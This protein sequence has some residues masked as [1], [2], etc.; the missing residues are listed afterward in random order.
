[1]DHTE[2]NFTGQGGLYTVGIEEELM[3]LDAESLDLANG[4]DRLVAE[5]DGDHIKPELHE[6]V[7]EIATAPCADV[8]EAGAQLRGLRDR[9]RERAAPQG[10][11]IAAAGTHPFAR[12]EDQRISPRPRYRDLIDQLGFVARQ[13]IIFGLHVHVGIDDPDKAIQVAN[14]LRLHVPVL[15]AL[16]A[17]S[18]FWRGEPTG[19]AARTPIFRQ[20]P[21]VGM[22]PRYD[23]WDD[24]TRRI[25][26]MVDAG[27]VA[28]HTWFWWD[29][30]I[31]PG[32]GTVE[33][34]SMDAQTRVEH[35]LALAALVQAMV[36]ELAEGHDA[37][38]RPPA[39]D[40]ELLSESK[41]QAARHGLEGELVDL[42]SADRVQAADL[43]RRLH[44]RLRPH[45]RQL[46]AEQELDGLLE[47]I[48]SGGG[49]ARQRLVFDANRDLR[50]VVSDLVQTS[51]GGSEPA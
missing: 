3:I 26:F 30:R 43:A 46:G 33:V 45:A 44:E 11:V 10:L 42:P 49:V 40:Q 34:R 31:S 24:W 2:H 8:P 21:R 4:M 36:K 19:V 9:V 32:F 27:M 1:M 23:D 25:A 5:N 29:V 37:G 12:W 17:N 38:E 16:S 7:L 41:W 14:G 15:Q 6:S 22:P 51:G 48:D 18:P 35:T 28:D 50:E 20:F 39:V 47:L 13:E